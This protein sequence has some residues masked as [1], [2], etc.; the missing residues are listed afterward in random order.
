MDD[1][2]CADKPEI[3]EALRDNIHEAIDGIQ[4]HTIENVFKNWA[5]R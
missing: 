4:L 2:C 1:E 3:I 5:D